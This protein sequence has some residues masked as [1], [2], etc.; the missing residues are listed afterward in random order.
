MDLTRQEIRRIA[1]LGGG[2]S[3]LLLAAVALPALLEWGETSVVSPVR[4]AIATVFVPVV[5]AAL[6]VAAAA[7]ARRL[8]PRVPA[9]VLASTDDP[10]AS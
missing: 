1:L 5:G 8:Q 6:A 7:A 10:T 3:A 2:F 9:V 4:L